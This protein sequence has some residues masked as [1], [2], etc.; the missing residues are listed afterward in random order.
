MG[1]LRERPGR[2]EPL[3]EAEVSRRL[4]VCA[5]CVK[6]YSLSEYADKTYGMWLC[7][8]CGT[9]T[10]CTHTFHQEDGKKMVNRVDMERPDAYR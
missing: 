8:W 9:Y 2:P 3:A 5:E 7:D 1:V 4:L 10:G 6:H